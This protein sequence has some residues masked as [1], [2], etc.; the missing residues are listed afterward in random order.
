MIVTNRTLKS[1]RS[2]IYVGIDPAS[3]GA[4]AV[5]DK[6]TVTVVL[7]W[8][9]VARK[10]K[11]H[12]QIK[13]ARDESAVETTLIKSNPIDLVREII[14]L[15][16]LKNKNI[17]M[18]IEDTYFSVNPSVAINLAKFS[19]RMCGFLEAHFDIES[20]WVRAA[21]WRKN[22]LD[23]SHF[24]KRKGAK[25]ASLEQIP[26]MA[27]NVKPILSV[28]GNHD[29][30]TDAIGISLWAR[31]QLTGDNGGQKNKENV[32]VPNETERDG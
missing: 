8:R 12:Y 17:H 21:D 27:N 4:V 30:I 13:I 10:K 5:L 9:K 24:T 3:S 7:Y 14:K 2:D 20:L 32:C 25:K 19:G 28:L 1:C 31:N 23:L 11:S 22:V 16:E 15:P 26:N 18:A 6:N 29:H